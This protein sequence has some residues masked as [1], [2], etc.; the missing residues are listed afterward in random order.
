MPISTAKKD[1]FVASSNAW[2]IPAEF[3]S[4]Y[5]DLTSNHKFVDQSPLPDVTGEYTDTDED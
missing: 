4:F 5:E 1:D 2:I 3:R